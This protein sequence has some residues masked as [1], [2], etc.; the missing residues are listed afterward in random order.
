LEMDPSL[1]FDF[2]VAIDP[3]GRIWHFDMDRGLGHDWFNKTDPESRRKKMNM[4]ALVRIPRDLQFWYTTVHKY[5]TK[6]IAG[7]LP[8]QE[9]KKRTSEE[10]YQEWKQRL[11][12]S[13]RQKQQRR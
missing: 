7:Y 13:D 8:L 4:L 10:Q 9:Q 3:H 5:I 2:Q 6:K 11:S 1:S 12:S